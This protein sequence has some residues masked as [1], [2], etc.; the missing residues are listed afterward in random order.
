MWQHPRTLFLALLLSFVAGAA[1]AAG[2]ERVNGRIRFHDDG[3]ARV[4]DHAMAQ[5]PSFCRCM[6]PTRTG[7]GYGW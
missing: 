2:P 7:R 3:I 6:H 1:D 5:S 4:F